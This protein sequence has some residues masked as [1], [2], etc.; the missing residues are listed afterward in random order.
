MVR[1]NIVVDRNF[2]CNATVM[3]CNFRTLWKVLPSK[4]TETWRW[5]LQTFDLPWKRY[6]CL[7]SV[8]SQYSTHHLC[9]SFIT[10]WNFIE[11]VDTKLQLFCFRKLYEWI[12]AFKTMNLIVISH[13]PLPFGA[14]TLL[15][16]P[17]QYSFRINE[18]SNLNFEFLKSARIHTSR[19]H[20][21]LELLIRRKRNLLSNKLWT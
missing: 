14:H 10:S 4:G 17:S 6:F 3:L 7:S 18:P 19:S 9:P 21:H 16:V 20:S 13:N 2:L 15:L 1:Y 11:N 8:T 5:D 12:S